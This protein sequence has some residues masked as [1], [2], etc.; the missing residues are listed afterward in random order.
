MGKLLDKFKKKT[1]V[2]EDGVMGGAPTNSVGSGAIAGIGI[3]PDGEPGRPK[4][5]MTRMRRKANVIKYVT[6]KKKKHK[7]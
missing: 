6:D 3:G 5:I 1:I 7:N 2:N 4:S